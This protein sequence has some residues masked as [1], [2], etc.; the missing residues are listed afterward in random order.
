MTSIK[1]P[2]KMP[3]TLS[4]KAK[5]NDK[6]SLKDSVVTFEVDIPD[7]HLIGLEVKVYWDN[8]RWRA[9]EELVLPITRPEWETMNKFLLEDTVNDDI[10]SVTHVTGFRKCEMV[11]KQID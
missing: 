1:D 6:I 11:L 7:S 10:L 4:D 9:R 5:F 2:N 3:R 8:C